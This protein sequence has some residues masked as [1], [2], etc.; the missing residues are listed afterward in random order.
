MPTE[1]KAQSIDKLEQELSKANIGILT[2]YR[3]LKTLE[4][5]ALRRKLQDA[6][7]DYKVVKNTLVQKAAERL[8]RTDIVDFFEGPTAVVFGYGDISQIA[9]AFSDHVRT[10][11]INLNVK[12]G[13]L[14]DR[15]LTAAEITTLATLPSK[16][17]LIAK[18]VGSIKSPLYMLAGVLTGPVRG[19]QNV[20]QGRIKQLEG[21]N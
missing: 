12:G 20:L 2:D 19:L 4:I 5:N 15:L 3:G 8:E 7:G 10:S 21:N 17:V 16:E 6:G 18:V 13:F 9:K 14:S 11:K 1:K